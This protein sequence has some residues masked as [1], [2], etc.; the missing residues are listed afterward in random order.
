M[1]IFTTE[2]L[3]LLG[4]ARRL[5]LNLTQQ[6]VAARAGVSRKWISEFELGKGG[7]E[8]APVLR[9]ITALSLSLDLMP[10][11]QRRAASAA[12]PVEDQVDLDVLLARYQSPEQDPS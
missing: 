6:A 10:I 8:L 11:Q 12:V 7:L 9:L 1:E 4:R 3:R 5:E 2:Q